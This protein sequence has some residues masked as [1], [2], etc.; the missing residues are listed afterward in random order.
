[1]VISACGGGGGGQSTAPTDSTGTPPTTAEASATPVPTIRATDQP[2]SPVPVPT[3]TQPAPSATPPP[4][5]EDSLD[6]IERADVAAGPSAREDHTWTVDGDGTTAYLFGGRDGGDTSDELWVFDLRTEEWAIAAP[7]GPSPDARFGHTATWVPEV[8]LVIW[9][10]QAGSTFFDD[11]WAYDPTA[12]AW[13]ELPSLGDVPP[14]RYGSC[15]S[16]GP[17]GR[18]WVS[19]GFTDT[20]RF[21]DTRAY[22]FATGEWADMSP[23]GATPV[24]RCLHDCFWAPDG[25]L[26]LYGGQTNG[27]AALGDLWSYD[28]ATGTWTESVEQVAPA[29]QLYALSSPVF[30]FGILVFGGGD[31][32]GGFLSDTLALDWGPPQLHALEVSIAPAARSGATLITDPVGRYLLFGGRDADGPL[33]DLWE[34]TSP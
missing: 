15:A 4:T 16:L 20:G 8:G 27:T 1:L 31:T 32:D 9:S 24:K 33:G 28:L 19:H 30:D 26:V 29:R 25:K 12:G 18:L 21:D 22:D 17:D 23:D 6:W 5:P 7:S 3:G 13:R 10:G 11:I 2:S 14:A 34:L